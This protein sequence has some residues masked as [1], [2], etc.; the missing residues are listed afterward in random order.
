MPCCATVSNASGCFSEEDPARANR[1]D[2]DGHPLVFYLHPEMERLHELMRLLVTH[3][4]D[5]NA[6]DLAGKTLLDCVLSHGRTDFSEVL[7][8]YG[9]VT[10]RSSLA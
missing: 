5:L 9:F 7:R 2:E 3:G 8:G 10:D 1:R 4:A 6:R